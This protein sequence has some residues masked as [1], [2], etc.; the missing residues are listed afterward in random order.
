M[1]RG[2][3]NNFNN[4][5]V[6]VLRFAQLIEAK[7]SDDDII[8]DAQ[9]IVKSALQAKELV[10]RLNRAVQGEKGSALLPIKVED[11][12]D[13]AIETARP[14]WKDEKEAEGTAIQIQTDLRDV[15]PIRGSQQGL[16]DILSS[17]IFNVV[18]ALPE[19]GSITISARSSGKSVIALCGRQ[20]HRNG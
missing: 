15:P 12:V 9:S 3:A 2:V 4:I 18:D 6:G 1:A 7:T 8:K 20:R 17:L 11:Q 19:G 16:R 14:R 13:D 5:L 10:D